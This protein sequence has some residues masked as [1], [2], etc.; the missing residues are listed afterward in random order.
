[1]LIDNFKMSDLGFGI[2]G[3]GIGATFHLAGIRKATGAKLVAV[4]D[5]LPEKAEKFAKENHIPAWYDNYKKLLARQDIEIISVCVPSGLHSDVAVEAAKAGK[6]ILC[7]KPIDIT[8][9]AADKMINAAEQAKV[10]L[11]IVLQWRAYENFQLIRQAVQS[12]ML[13]KMVLGDVY[14]KYYRSQDYYDSAE[15]RGTWK[16]DGGGAL[17]NQGVHG[18]DLVQWI[19]G[20][21]ESVYA[22]ADHLVRDI[23]VE[24]TAVVVLT[25]KN[26]AYGIIQGTTSVYPGEAP[27]VELHGELGTIILQEQL[28]KKWV[29]LGNDGKPNDLTP[30]GE[31]LNIA[32]STD[33]IA[34]VSLGHERCVQ[35][36]IDA[37][38]ENK[39]LFCSG[40]ESRKSLEIIIAI[41]QSAQTGKA[42][43]L[44]L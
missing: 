4:A 23:E 22:K 28:I 17:M 7:E 13:G 37:V 38:V 29:V 8:L 27:R 24:D 43:Q 20:D 35:N 44:P 36:I 1:L 3:C 10:K 40:L 19:M 16:F 41:Y 18:I 15:W 14:L 32:G 2:I 6:H 25:Y 34:I 11:G 26:G 5:K 30:P 42:I 9:S 33:P 21:V 39:P 31:Q 12:G